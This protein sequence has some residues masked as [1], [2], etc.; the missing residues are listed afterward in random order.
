[1]KKGDS[2]FHVVRDGEKVRVDAARTVWL[3]E[4][5]NAFVIVGDNLASE[6]N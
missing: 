2:F 3:Q 6:G 5:G 1:M 4:N